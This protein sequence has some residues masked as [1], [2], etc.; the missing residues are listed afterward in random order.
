MRFNIMWTS[1][2]ERIVHQTVLVSVHDPEE[3]EQKMVEL[4]ASVS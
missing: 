1:Y 4:A 3:I 2:C